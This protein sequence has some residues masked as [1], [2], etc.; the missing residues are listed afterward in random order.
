MAGGR[1]A[2]VVGTMFPQPTVAGR[3]LDDILGPDFA[4]LGPGVTQDT[5]DT[6][7]GP[8]ARFLRVV[9]SGSAPTE[10]TV[11]EIADDTL[12]DW[13]TR[14]RVR[15][16]VL[17]PDRFVYGTDTDDLAALLRARSRHLLR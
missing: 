7:E 2:G 12:A 11:G 16:V 1:R 5:V 17:R 15:Q 10:D 9:P 13:F 8:P 3:P 14:H 4:V 6:W